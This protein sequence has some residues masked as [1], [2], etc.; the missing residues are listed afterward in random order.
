MKRTATL[1][2][3]HIALLGT[4]TSYAQANVTDPVNQCANLLSDRTIVSGYPALNSPS[5][6]ASA[7]TCAQR[8]PSNPASATSER[9]LQDALALCIKQA[10]D[11]SPQPALPKQTIEIIA[12]LFDA[13]SPQ[14]HFTPPKFQLKGCKLPEYP[15][16][17][18]RAEAMGLSRI[19]LLV[20]KTGW[21]LDAEV[22]KSS[23][24]TPAHKLLD[25]M[26]MFNLMSCRMEPAH[27]QDKAV[28]AWMEMSYAW[29]LE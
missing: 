24:S 29:R 22:V 1:I 25:A 2:C 18:Q 5:V 4:S 6:R 9:P 26:T 7:C 17:A 15:D 21:V 13:G 8:L 3:L 19:A 12:N 23:G 28:E 11:A 20:S 10:T 27:Y 16:A 14:S